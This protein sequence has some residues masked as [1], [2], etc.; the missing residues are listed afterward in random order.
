MKYMMICIVVIVTLSGCS[1]KEMNKI[2]D[3]IKEIG[4]EGAKAMNS[5]G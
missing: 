1:S 4:N 3:G 2:T 5:K